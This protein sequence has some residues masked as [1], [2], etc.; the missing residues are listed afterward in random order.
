MRRR[1]TSLDVSFLQVE[2]PC[3]HRHVG[4]VA[5]LAP[6][7]G[8][9]AP[10]FDAIR[11]HVAG[12]LS[13][14][15]RYRQRLAPVPLGLGDPVWVDA[16]GFDV[17]HH[18]IHSPASELGDVVDAV[19][20][21]PLRRDRPLWELWVADQLADG[22]IGIVGK[23]HHCMVD[24]IAAVELASLLLDPEPVPPPPDA[25]SWRPEPPPGDIDLVASAVRDRLLDGMRLATAPAELVRSPRRVLARTLQA[26]DALGSSL[27]PASSGGGLNDPISP[28]R[29]LACSSC[30]LEE[31]Q[32]VK[33]RFGTTLNDVLLAVVAGALR[34]FML[35]REMEPERLK[36]MVPVNVR[37]DGAAGDLGNRISFIFVELP[38]DEPDPVRRLLNVHLATSERK[39]RGDAQGGD[40]VLRAFAYTPRTLQAVVSRLVASPRTFN[41]VVSNIPGPRDPLY[42]L[43]CELEEAYPV[44]PL[45]DRHALSVGVTTIR[46]GAF[47]GLYADR[48]TLPDADVLSAEIDLA[49]DELLEC[50][51]A[52]AEPEREPEPAPV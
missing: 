1:L 6:P 18:V 30:R 34:S 8:S 45:A 20:S 14:A 51:A 15:P 25:D 33:R 11:D 26:M 24:G 37:E 35:W 29:H 50:A 49:V 44:V 9:D 52:E 21:V 22:R 39:R 17:N 16:E 2:T 47:F 31:L 28:G 4:W 13:R 27:L 48:A 7:P 38:C 10:G 19:M 42:M 3:A 43:G 46:D 12:R 36:A 40:A 23:A 32:A 5:L 41:L